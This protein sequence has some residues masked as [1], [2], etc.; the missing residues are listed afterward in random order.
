MKQ[1]RI[2]SEHFVP[3]GEAGYTDAFMDQDQLSELKRL[4][5]LP[6]LVNEN[7]TALGG[8]KG[9][10][11]V[12]GNL[13]NVP[14]AQETGITSPVGSNISVT[15]RDRDAL[16]KKYNAKPGDELWFLINF[17]P[18]R[19]LG[20]NAGTLEQKITNY[21]QTHPAERQKHQTAD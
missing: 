21:L 19:G 12:G 5:G 9:A 20:A 3:Q 17:E 14:Q 1:Y 18:V 11:P 8:S 10:G 2:T 13:D 4:A 16:L 7:E 6:L 15:A